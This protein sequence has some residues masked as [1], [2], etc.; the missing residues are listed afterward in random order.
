MST[1]PARSRGVLICDDLNAIRDLLRLIIDDEPTMHV[2]GE[3]A[4]GRAAISE[5]GRLQPDVILLDLAMPVMTGMEALPELRRI[6]PA[7]VIIVLSGFASTVAGSELRALGADAYVEKGSSIV[8]I[9][10]TIARFAAKAALP[11]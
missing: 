3:A 4:D 8:A 5:A 6:A 2:V 11:G 7:A 1:R 9:V 10:D